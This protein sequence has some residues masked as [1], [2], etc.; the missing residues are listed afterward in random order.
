MGLILFNIFIDDMFYLMG[1]A[2]ICNYA[3][4]YFYTCDTAI[5][6]VIHKLEEYGFDIASWLSKRFMKLDEES[7]I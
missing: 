6:L 2:E 4:D 7:F 3:D 5:D 1:E